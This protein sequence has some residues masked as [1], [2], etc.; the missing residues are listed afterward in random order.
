M[1]K[2]LRRQQKQIS[3]IQPAKFRPLSRR[4]KKLVI[5]GVMGVALGFW[6]LTFADPAGQNWPSTASPAILVLSYGLV[7]WGLVAS[8]STNPPEVP[9]AN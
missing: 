4:G 6:V 8:D 1:A 9:P 3:E 5:A 2:N 7:G